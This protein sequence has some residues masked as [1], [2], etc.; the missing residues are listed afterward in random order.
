VV[1]SWAHRKWFNLAR[2]AFN[3]VVANNEKGVI[4]ETTSQMIT[5]SL[6]ANNLGGG[7]TP[8]FTNCMLSLSKTTTTR[9]ELTTTDP[10]YRLTAASPCRNALPPFR[11]TRPITIST[12]RSGRRKTFS[13]AALTSSDPLGPP[14]LSK[15]QRPSLD[16]RW[17]DA[18]GFVYGRNRGHDTNCGREWTPGQPSIGGALAHAASATLEGVPHMAE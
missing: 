9:T 7:T 13:T 4:C 6:V 10:K 5:A 11:Q 8:D 3:T 18:T 15:R 16:S 14:R 1:R 2:F 12:E 17:S